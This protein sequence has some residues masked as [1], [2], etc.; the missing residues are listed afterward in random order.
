MSYTYMTDQHLP[1]PPIQVH[2][3]IQ[4]ISLNFLNGCKQFGR[5]LCVTRDRL[6]RGL[7]A[8]G[9]R[10]GLPFVRICAEM[11]FRDFF[12]LCAAFKYIFWVNWNTSKTR[13]PQRS[14]LRVASVCY[15]AYFV[16]KMSGLLLKYRAV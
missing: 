15:H 6:S 5:G 1:N 4:T 11:S 3:F 8:Y 2:T 12:G 16:T 7:P 9:L 10:L 13:T 14:F